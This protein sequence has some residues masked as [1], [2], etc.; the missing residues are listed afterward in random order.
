MQPRPRLSLLKQAALQAV[1]LP[2]RAARRQIRAAPPV[3]MIAAL[4]IGAMAGGTTAATTARTIA[5]A[6]A[7]A[8]APVA[9]RIPVA[10]AR[11]AT[12]A[13]K[14]TVQPASRAVMI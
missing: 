3:L 1:P 10:A 8:N 7:L 5:T 2:A 13:R 14:V 12:H 4:M 9:V 11:S 6:L